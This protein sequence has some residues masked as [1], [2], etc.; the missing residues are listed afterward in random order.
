[1]E[2]REGWFDDEGWL[3]DKPGD[4]RNWWF[5]DQSKPVVIG[6]GKQRW[7]ELE[8]QTA[9]RMWLEHGKAYGLELT[10][11]QLTNYA[12]AAASLGRRMEPTPEE[13]DNPERR[14][15]F[16]TGM[17]MFYYQQNRSLTNFPYF[18]T[19]ANC[20][21]RHET[22]M[23]R[24]KLWEAEEQ[25]KLG[26]KTRAIKLYEQGLRL[27]REVLLRDADFHRPERSDHTEEETYTYELAYIRLLVQDDDRVRSKANAAVEQANILVKLL[28][29]PVIKNALFEDFF[30]RHGAH[31]LSSVVTSADMLEEAK[32]SIAEN[33][34]EFSPFVGVMDVADNDKRKGQPWIRDYIKEN[35]RV[36][37]GVQRRKAAPQLSEDV[38]PTQMPPGRPQMPPGKKP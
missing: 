31:M 9:A 18:L 23:A 21:A 38:D 22:V 13:M 36:Q 34:P 10:P 20:E 33:D 26:E 2:Q 16:Q 8:W 6:G 25:R 5:P 17:A 15:H 35:I 12:Q 4:Q 30:V 32:W 27:W 28:Q 1:M 7:S 11:E 3:V 37:Q 29:V 24:K 19:S 14:R